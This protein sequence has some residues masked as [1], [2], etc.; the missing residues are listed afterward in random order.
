MASKPKYIVIT[1]NNSPPIQL[2]NSPVTHIIEIPFKY[3][4]KEFDIFNGEDIECFTKC[5]RYNLECKNQ[6][7]MI[8]P[9]FDY[10]YKVTQD[11]KSYLTGETL[12]NI[13]I[14]YL[15]VEPEVFKN[16]TEPIE[17]ILSALMIQNSIHCKIGCEDFIFP[18][19]MDEYTKINTINLIDFINRNSK[20]VKIII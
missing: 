20:T 17:D 8:K 13:L 16:M 10:D 12:K 7:E 5:L 11:T 1:V 9:Q 3:F 19:K 14:E 4:A 6:N 15:G 18:L 2:S